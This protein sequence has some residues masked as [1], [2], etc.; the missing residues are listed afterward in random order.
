M[1]NKTGCG[2]CRISAL[3]AALAALVI[4]VT[5]GSAQTYNLLLSFNGPLSKI[6]N[7]GMTIDSAGNVY[8]TRLSDGPSY[9]G[10]VY[11][12]VPP[13]TQGG[14]WSEN[15]LYAFQGSADG[16][17]PGAITVGSDGAI[18]GATLGGGD[19]SNCAAGCGTLFKLTPPSNGG[20]W[21]KTTLYAFLESTDVVSLTVGEGGILFAG[22]NGTGTLLNGAI[23]SLAPTHNGWVESVTYSFTGGADGA[24]PSSNL[25]RDSAGNFYGVTEAGGV[26]TSGTPAG[27][28]FELSPPSGSDG[29][30]TETTLHTFNNGTGGGSPGGNLV[31]DTSG[32]IFGTTVFGGKV[33]NYG[34]RG[35][36]YSWSA[37]RGFRLLYTFTGDAGVPQGV[38]RNPK[39]RTL[40]GVQTY[41]NDSLYQLTPT[42]AGWQYS[43]LH[44]FD[45]PG[46]GSDP[47]HLVIDV[48]G[49]LFGVTEGGGATGA[50]T[51]YQWIP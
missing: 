7:G 45:G 15:V 8:G 38:V 5:P 20:V 46:D 17:E 29:V 34:G 43:V 6:T 16:S 36:A 12:L 47:T 51:A 42:A 4:A 13:N 35:V 14:S 21:T 19:T 41:N 26:V 25:L 39:T 50:G 1:R 3:T 11:Q 31:R 18:Y 32:T 23:I 22:A 28:L 27:V 49:D 24:N 9:N 44:A 48:N 30:W 37:S 10:T 40:Y 2:L 33:K